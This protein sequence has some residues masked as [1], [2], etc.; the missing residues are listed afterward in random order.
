MALTIFCIA[1]LGIQI[2]S[3]IFLLFAFGKSTIRSS[4]EVCQVSV[5]VC[6]HDEEENLRELIP[7]LLQQPQAHYVQKLGQES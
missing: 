4:N 3:F 1:V 2:V 7:L 5:I 6:A